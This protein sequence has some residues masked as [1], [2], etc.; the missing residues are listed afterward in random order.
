MLTW[1]SKLSLLSGKTIWDLQDIP[2]H[3]SSITLSD[4][5]HGVRKP[6]SDLTLQQA[7]PSTCFP[8]GCALA[9]S[10]DV[11]VLEQV[12][13]ALAKECLSQN[14]QILL[15]PA[16]NLKRHPAGGRNL[17]Y[18]SEDP[19]L[20]GTLAAAYIQGV[21]ATGQVG[22]C[23]KHF[24]VN[25]Q[26]SHR[27]V[28]NAIVD[29][30]TLRELYLTGFELAMASN[31]AMVMGAYNKVNGI[32][33]CQS[34][35]LLDT[36]LRKEFRFQG[37]CVTDWGATSDRVA[38]IRASMDLEMPGN[39]GLYH[40]E[41]TDAIK[42]GRLSTEEVDRCVDRIV[43]LIQRYQSMEHSTS[44][45]RDDSKND[46]KK[47]PF[48]LSENLL[49]ENHKLAHKLAMECAVL[50]KNEDS[51]LPLSTH[52]TIA[53]IGDF[54]K[55]NPRYQGM[56]SSHVSPTQVETAYAA[57]HK[58]T[59]QVF[60]SPGYD[61]DTNDDSLDYDSIHRA[62]S[63]AQKGDAVVLF[64]GLPEICESEGFDRPNLRMPQQHLALWQAIIEVHSKVVV[65]LNNGGVVEFPKPLLDKTGA[66]LEAYLLGQAGASAIMDLVFGKAS[67]CGRLPETMPVHV[68]DLPANRYFPGTRNVVEYR[69]GLDIGYR[70]LDDTVP[71]TPVLFPFGHGLTYTTF[72]YKQLK[73]QVVEDKIKEKQVLVSFQLENTGAWAAKEV[74]QC[75]IHP[76]NESTTVYRPSH[77]LKAFSKIFLK[78]GENQEVNFDLK[79]RA[80]AF[81][82]IGIQDWIIE[83]SAAFEV[84]IGASSRNIH[85]QQTIQF[86]KGHPSSQ[87]ARESYPPQ[88]INTNPVIVGDKTFAKRFGSK[89]DQVL[90]EI[91]RENEAPLLST[92]SFSNPVPL[93][94]NSLLKEAALCS[95]IGK[96]FYWTVFRI[97]CLEIKRGSPS[98]RR[99]T[100]MIQANVENL[101]LR[102]VALFSKGG[103][104]LE[105][106]DTLIFA[107]NG[108]YLC[109][110]KSLGTA[111][112]RSF[113][114]FVAKIVVLKECRL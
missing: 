95:R 101:P 66:V 68:H 47:D 107:M 91:R 106:L 62:Q 28:V 30:R 23:V 36:I 93:H 8:A 80:F 92:L 90:N 18:F 19:Y 29:E 79:H 69:E 61:A 11:N 15:G 114:G 51:I 42:D 60:F 43:T 22:A 41:I 38:S 78:P 46:K 9:C 63:V 25:N 5:P 104:T 72:E 109:A 33:C 6:L 112:R 2:P 57:C 1:N 89:K 73:V 98:E 67:P 48:V 3:L 39:N 99:E 53:L 103:L 45:R 65:V 4:G 40:R 37:V 87:L 85:L 17:E 7:H 113:L 94:R 105:L 74:I 50:L 82:D 97:A 76:I 14:V 71:P 75:Y 21:Q 81:Y 20:T 84:Q 77:E 44:S 12:G 110:L 83:P 55:D 13:A 64:L 31:P 32:Y 49:G 59:S 108:K 27:M 10:W 96:V 54:A 100:R 35:Y 111:I 24:A 88:T 86:T 70:Y 16:M 58:Y 56:G 26:E 34:S 102:S 52:Q